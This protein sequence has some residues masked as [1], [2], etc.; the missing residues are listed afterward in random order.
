HKA[1]E[2]I[3]LTEEYYG[4]IRRPS[5]T[6]I[7]HHN[8]VLKLYKD[9]KISSRDVGSGWLCTARPSSRLLH[10]VGKCVKMA[11]FLDQ[12]AVHS[13]EKNYA[14]TECGKIFGSN[15][16]LQT[17]DCWEEDMDQKDIKSALLTHMDVHTGEKKYKCEE[18]GKSYY[19]KGSLTEHMLVHTGDNNFNCE[20]C[21]KTYSSKVTLNRHM[22]VHTGEK[23]FK[24]DDCDKSYY[25]ESSLK[26]HMII[27]TGEKNFKCEVCGKSY[28]SNGAL[29]RHTAV[30]TGLTCLIN[31]MRVHTGY[32]NFIVK[33][34]VKVL[35]SK[36]I[37]SIISLYT[38]DKEDNYL[39]D[40]FSER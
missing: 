6:N 36:M 29:T 12:V 18:C 4:S 10:N 15:E 37:L 23:K 24:C 26:E 27:H 32:V 35:H 16:Y 20:E 25:R 34:M 17:H 19:R 30:H 14:C 40:R 21:G 3:Q 2:R 38:V 8:L 9:H 28:F 31:H 39:K 33:S 1:C 13:D 22:V 11:H 5:Q 7:S